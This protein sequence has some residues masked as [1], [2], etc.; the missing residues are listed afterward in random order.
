MQIELTLMVH[1]K[2]FGLLSANVYIKQFV[3]L[4]LQFFSSPAAVTVICDNAAI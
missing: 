3:C 1:V 2:T 4:F